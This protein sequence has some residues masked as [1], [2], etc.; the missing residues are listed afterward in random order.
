MKQV[1][2]RLIANFI[3]ILIYV[4]LFAL[5]QQKVCLFFSILLISISV[6]AQSTFENKKSNSLLKQKFG[7][8]TFDEKE[9]SIQADTVEHFDQWY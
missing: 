7:W 8:E 2:Y 5:L 1:P 4:I 9:I 6:S 3:Q